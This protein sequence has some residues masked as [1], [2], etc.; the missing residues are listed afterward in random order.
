MIISQETLVKEKDIFPKP[1]SPPEKFLVQNTTANH[2]QR[3]NLEKQNVN[4]VEMVAAEDSHMC[5]LPD[6]L[7][8]ISSVSTPSKISHITGLNEDLMTEFKVVKRTAVESKF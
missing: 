1:K 5:K 8:S 7:R 3:Q 2:A 4:D 6:M